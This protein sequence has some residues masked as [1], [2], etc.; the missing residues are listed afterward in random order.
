VTKNIYLLHL[1]NYKYFLISQKNTPFRRVRDDEVEVSSMLGNNS[2]EA[3]VNARKQ[4][5][6]YAGHLPIILKGHISL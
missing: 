4:Q 1:F 2:F 5:K 3:K 6:R